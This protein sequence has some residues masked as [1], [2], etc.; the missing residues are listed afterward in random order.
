M[1]IG[2]RVYYTH[3]VLH[4]WPDSDC[5]K[6]LENLKAAM[7]PGYSR[8]LLNESIIPDMNCPSFFAA[9]DINMMAIVAGLKRTREQWLLLL[10]SVD[11]EVVDIWKSPYVGDEEGVIEAVV[12]S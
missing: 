4:D 2:A 7:E 11:L 3:F 1:W 10:Q 5:R 9:G 6:I 12:A 8:L